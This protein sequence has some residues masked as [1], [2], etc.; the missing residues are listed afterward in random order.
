MQLK[1]LAD[2]ILQ[3]QTMDRAYLTSAPSNMLYLQSTNIKNGFV[4]EEKATYVAEKF[5]KRIS[6][7]ELVSSGDIIIHYKSDTDLSIFRFTQDFNKSIIASPNFVVIKSPNSFLTNVIQH[8]SGKSYFKSEIEDM[9]KRKEGNWKFVAAELPFIDIPLVFDE[10]ANLTIAPGNIPVDKNDF[11]QISIR[12]GIISADNLIK[13]VNLQEIRIDGYFQRKTQ[14]WDQGTKSRLIETLIL[15]IPVPPLYFDVVS[16]SEWLIID[17]LQRISTITDFYNNKFEL[18][19]LDFLPELNG[20]R[21]RDLD[22]SI[23]RNIEEAEITSFSIQPGTPRTVRYKIFKNINTSALILTRQEIRH[24]MNEDEEN[25]SFTSSKYIKELADILN[26]YI[27]IPQSEIDRMYDREL[28]LRYVTFRMFYYKTDYKPS[29]AD[30][31][32]MS[33]ESMY[34][35]PKNKLEVYK[36]DF[37][38]ALKT[39]TTL[40]DAENLF[41]KRMIAPKEEESETRKVINGSLFETWT[42]AVSQLT[43]QKREV[44]ISKSRKLMER[45]T[46][47]SQD[48]AFTRSIDSRYFN[49]IEMV[50]T[51]FATTLQLINDIIND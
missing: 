48:T 29:M 14:L 7:A 2:S 45:T 19:E 17:G 11:A 34:T 39:L 38:K 26:R 30:F 15:D 32:D 13:R 47:L 33:M 22:R 49:A 18:T 44:L 43:D 25:D 31:L 37:E 36:Y 35:Y 51:R 4:T 9:L 27:P 20:K 23:Q 12:K 46:A 10:Q 8:E 5:A 50:K 1:D 42:Y 6:K 28:A 21:F 3:G 24:A 41:S 40:F 16:K